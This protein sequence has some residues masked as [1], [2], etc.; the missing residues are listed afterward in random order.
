MRLRRRRSPPRVLALVAFRDERRFLPGLLENLRG[1]VDGIVALDD[2]SADGSG[3]LAAA[4]PE[5]VEVLRSRREDTSRW[6]EGPL[7]RALT[8]A[9]RRHGADWLLGIDADERVE[10]GFRERAAA[11]I[12]RA[13]R[14]GNDAYFVHFCEA[15]DA[16]DRIRVDGWFGRKRKA[17]LFRAR[18]DHRFDARGLHG[19]WAPL[20]DHPDE[21][22]P[23]ADLLLYHLRMIRPEDRLARRRR[24]ERLDPER[25]HQAIGYEYLTDESGLRLEP[26]PPGRGYRPWPAPAA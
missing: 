18:D 15:W 16:P 26:L 9:G 10:E 2:G 4:C 12:A 6:E 21:E 23:Q 17:A 1:Q 20:N 3:E 11:E 14:E 13:E 8:A 24:Y 7:R 19:H 25:A 5:V 22:F